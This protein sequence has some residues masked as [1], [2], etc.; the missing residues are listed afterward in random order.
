MPFPI[1]IIAG[2]GILLSTTAIGCASLPKSK[3]SNGIPIPP[4]LPVDPAQLNNQLDS[5]KIN[6]PNYP[7]DLFAEQ[8][9]KDRFIRIDSWNRFCEKSVSSDCA[10]N[11][12]NFE[13][14][15]KNPVEWMIERAPAYRIAQRNNHEIDFQ[16]AALKTEYE[17]YIQSLPASEI[18]NPIFN[19]ANFLSNWKLWQSK[20]TIEFGSEK[21]EKIAS[22]L[23]AAFHLREAPATQTSGSSFTPED[24]SDMIYSFLLGAFLTITAEELQKLRDFPDKKKMEDLIISSLRDLQLGIRLFFSQNENLKIFP[25]QLQNA[26]SSNSTVVGNYFPDVNK[27][28]LS[29]TLEDPKEGFFDNSW[30]NAATHEAK[31][32]ENDRDCGSMSDFENEMEAY[33]MGA[34]FGEL[35]F[36]FFEKPKKLESID[37]S[38]SDSPFKMWARMV[39]WQAGHRPKAM[40]RL[41]IGYQEW[42]DKR[43]YSHPYWPNY[44]LKLGEQHVVDFYSTLALE[45]KILELKK[46]DRKKLRE[47]YKKFALKGLLDPNLKRGENPKRINHQM[48]E[49]MVRLLAIRVILNLEGTDFE[50]AKKLIR[51]SAY[52]RMKLADH[53]G[54][55]GSCGP[56]KTY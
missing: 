47:E 53:D 11:S 28:A 20:H 54:I 52:I 49:E 2:A 21:Y 24:P 45:N 23:R 5:H 9:L 48:S 32:R 38:F 26:T 42:M 34:L 43:I 3:D 10:L 37:N 13:F 55:N 40:D 22:I 50:K 46:E 19:W 44:L 1:F 33:K 25:S 8:F 29:F 4:L 56:K 27:I 7:I 31:H 41:K 15:N 51:S 6:H 18:P 35:L 14:F 16:L 30:F 12:K 17:K 36:P 39:L